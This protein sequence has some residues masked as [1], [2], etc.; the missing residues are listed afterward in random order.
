MLPINSRVSWTIVR[1]VIQPCHWNRGLQVYIMKVNEPV[2]HLNSQCERSL[3]FDVFAVFMIQYVS[4][5]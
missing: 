3:P 4:F 1:C 5:Y 2:M